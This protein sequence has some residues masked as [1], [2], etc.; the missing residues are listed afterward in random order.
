MSV[1]WQKRLAIAGAALVLAAFF[2]A[3]A[4][5]IQLATASQPDCTVQPG[6][7]MVAKRAC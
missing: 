1:L 2:G 3:N 6:G 4:R 7:P 5:M